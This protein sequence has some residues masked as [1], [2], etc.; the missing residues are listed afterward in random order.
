MV[1]LAYR[2]RSVRRYQNLSGIFLFFISLGVV[3][4]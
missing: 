2:V 1:L 4:E 3:C